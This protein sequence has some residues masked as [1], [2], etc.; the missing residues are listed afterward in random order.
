MNCQEF[1]LIVHDLAGNGAPAP[2]A[3][4]VNYREQGLFHAQECDRCSTLFA[5]A[6][7]LRSSLQ[8]L[9]VSDRELTAPEHIEVA[10]LQAFQNRTSVQPLAHRNRWA[11]AGPALAAAAVV[12]M[13]LVLSM[14]IGNKQRA[15]SSPQI[16]GALANSAE[17]TSAANSAQPEQISS[18]SDSEL[19]GLQDFTA[20]PSS[21]D[22]LV[23]LD[24]GTV[25]RVTT[26]RST[27]ES[28]GMTFP[29]VSVDQDN[30]EIS[31][32]LLIDQMGMPRAI[33]LGQQQQ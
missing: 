30:S 4:A 9:A 6:R 8:R 16:P 19:A 10:L 24:S 7:S 32:D 33:R 26:T 25:V 17:S 22:D 1:E 13:A 21:D 18:L 29:S 23:P 31:A 28:L 12:L 27:L 5:E 2:E 20:L 3:H 11:L 15:G 14:H